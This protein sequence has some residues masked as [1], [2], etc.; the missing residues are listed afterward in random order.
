MT[1]TLVALLLATYLLA[2]I[3]FS[4][5]VMKLAGK[6]DPRESG[7]GNAGATNIRRQAGTFWAGV[8]LVLELGKAGLI[9]SS[10]RYFLPE[11]MLF[12]PLLALILGNRWS[13]FYRFRGGKGV[14]SYLG[15]TLFAMPWAALAGCVGWLIVYGLTRHSFFGS[16]VMTL[17]CA[18]GIL[19]LPGNIWVAV[20]VVLI[21]TAL[22]FHAHLPNWRNWRQKN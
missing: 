6:E 8:V 1:A 20:P 17:S 16:G 21:S 2:S 18:A 12:P 7:S 10:A 4:I 11:E 9:V 22:V 13:I 15:F 19:C 14:A 5:L 3:N